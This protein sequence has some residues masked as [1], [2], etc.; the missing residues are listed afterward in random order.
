MFSLA[1]NCFLPESWKGRWFQSGVSSPILID[2]KSMA[3]KGTCYERSGDKFL[4]VA[5]EK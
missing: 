2:S 5:S 4:F 3:E 1:D